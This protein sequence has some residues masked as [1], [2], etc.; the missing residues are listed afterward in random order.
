MALA[1][2][3]KW[4][5]TEGEERGSQRPDLVSDSEA[6]ELLYQAVAAARVRDVPALC[7]LGSIGEAC[8]P[9]LREVGGPQSNWPVTAPR[10][11][12][13]KLAITGHGPTGVVRVLKLTV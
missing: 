5:F 9:E 3:Y 8:A 2:S 12:S 10:V 4:G 13:S 6:R 11:L 1:G 7:E